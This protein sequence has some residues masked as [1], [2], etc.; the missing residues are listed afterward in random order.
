[1]TA[2][3]LSIGT[4]VPG[5]PFDQA[6]ARDL[7]AAQPGIDRLAAR[8]IHSAF[9]HSAI[10]TRHAVI[11]GQGAGGGSGPGEPVLGGSAQSGSAQSGSEL[12]HPAFVDDSG[13]IRTPTTGE[14]NAIYRAEAPA[15]F[16]DAARSALSEAEFTPGEV[17]H[18][19]T[20][21][22]TGFFSP[23]PDFL[24]VRDLGLAT[25]V[26]RTHI[27]FM[28]CSAAF[29]ALRTASQICA[30]DPSAVVL[31]VCAEI[32]SIHLR[33]STDTEQIV[34]SAVFADGAAA[35][36]VVGADHATPP[37]SPSLQLGE[38]NTF[39]T[40]EGEGDMDWTVGD[41]GF[42]MR[43][44]ANV[45]RIIGR[46]IAG[47]AAQLPGIEFSD[48]WAVHPGGRSVLDR[49][50]AGLGL[51][52]DALD[53]SRAVLREYGNMSSATVLF[54]LRRLLR[55]DSLRDGAQVAGLAF[56]PGLTVEAARFV[57]QAG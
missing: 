50:Q 48:A 40:D 34:A 22:C 18:V 26:P 49:A 9:D 37:A 39:I 46:E 54:I 10:E 8:L 1:M 41:Q 30:A 32:C 44:T 29:P 31:V 56:G 25:T 51:R 24:L 28:G 43:L 2:R 15:L 57:R 55:D 23:G 35:A 38:F 16:A 36:V 21:S 14:R 53:H 7:F 17:S 4:A 5:P 12:W 3:I 33:S 47:V 27:G 13:V 19:V 52:D 45:P 6:A 20:A 42:E 11:G